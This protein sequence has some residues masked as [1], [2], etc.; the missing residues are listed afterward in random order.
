M[1]E[2]PLNIIECMEDPALFQPW[3]VGKSWNAWRVALKAA[4]A[5]PMTSA[6]R[7]LF[8]VLA[9][10]EPPR[11]PVRELWAVC[12]RR[13]GKDSVASLIAAHMAAFFDP[14]GRLRRGERASVL[15]LATDK[16]QASIVLNYIKAFFS[17]IGY[18]RSMVERETVNGLELSN[19]VE[20]IV[21]PNDFR[22]V[23]GRAIA[24]AIL[25]E[26]AFWRSDNSA[27][28]D[29]EVFS[30]IKPGTMTVAGLVVGISSPHKKS[31]LLYERWKEHY[32]R[33]DSDVMV[34]RAPSATMNPTLDAK[35]IAAEI[36]RDPAVGKAE[37][38]AEWRDDLAT[39]LDRLLIE[40]AV[41]VGVTVRPRIRNV[42]YRC[43]IDPSGGVGD[44]MTLGISHRGENDVVVLD[45]IV[46]RPAPF[47]AQQI[48]SDFAKIMRE[49]GVNTCTSDRYAS[50]WVI[51]VLRGMWDHPLSLGPR[52]L[53]NLLRRVTAFY[54]RQGAV[55]R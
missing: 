22:A 37:W 35:Q 16:S 48:V 54:E 5:L 11:K 1:S 50:S 21:S 33:D 42:T 32:G 39:F 23:R 29:T 15:C 4:F 27:S 30:A 34:I 26:L 10:R 51:A 13:A 19:G 46:E 8:R 40:A 7:K 45:C 53:G 9:E 49:Y 14:C 2:A 18:L 12:G 6:E 36:A 44:S 25:D 28:P 24:L 17:D 41:D 43:F 47:Q 55:A 20:I 52:P 38:L 31:G 3:F